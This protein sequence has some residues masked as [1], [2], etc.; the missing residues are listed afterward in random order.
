MAMAKSFT[1]KLRDQAGEQWMKVVHHKFTTEL[2]AGTINRNVLKKYLIQDHRFLDSFVVLLASM[3]ANCR[4][5]EDRIPGC[6]F[7]ALITDKE[8]T[9]FERSFEAMGCTEEERQSIPNA[10]CTQGFIDLM[11]DAAKSGNLGE[12]LAVLVVCEWSYMTWGELVLESTVREDFACYEWV[13]LHSGKFFAGVVKYLR[14]LLDKEESFL[15]EAGKE[16]VKQ[17]FMKAIELEEAFFENA[18]S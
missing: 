5:L 1:E 17:R 11:H 2:A 7:I 13:D 18:Y 4:T 3:I 6:Q 14:S 16:A 9:Y 8:N 12:I 10:Q 15:D